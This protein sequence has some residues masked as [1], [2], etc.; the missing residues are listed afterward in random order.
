MA[1][2]TF[3][4]DAR[5]WRAQSAIMDALEEYQPTSWSFEAALHLALTDLANEIKDEIVHVYRERDIQ[6]MN[7]ST[8]ANIEFILSL[9][10][11][12][13]VERRP[14]NNENAD[15]LHQS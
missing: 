2:P 11:K 9:R 5:I 1:E 10:G 8:R 13:I 4:F 6:A 15:P 12:D 14:E 7:E 3:D